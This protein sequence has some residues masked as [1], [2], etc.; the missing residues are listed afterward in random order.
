[1]AANA[2]ARG[3]RSAIF[4]SRL[5]ELDGFVL[6]V[7]CGP[8]GCRGERSYMI[9]EL[10]ALLGGDRQ[11]R[12]VLARMRCTPGCGAPVAAAWLATGPVLNARVRPRR[13]PL[14]GRDV[15]D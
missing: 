8:P 3:Q 12:D 7:D 6:V 13:V 9:S 10:A 1:M 11:V 14:I 15:R 4:A 5:R 2:S